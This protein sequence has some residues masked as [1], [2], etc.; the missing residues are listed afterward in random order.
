MSG[1]K[2]ESA[3]RDS[4]FFSIEFSKCEIVTNYKLNYLF[5][6]SFK[7]ISFLALRYQIN[8]NVGIDK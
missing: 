6:F 5:N 1:N 8:I 7:F 3:I 4:R 2:K